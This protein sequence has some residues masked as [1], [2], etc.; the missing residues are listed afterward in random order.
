MKMPLHWFLLALL[1][2]V[3][4]SGASAEQAFWTGNVPPT[5]QARAAQVREWLEGFRQ[6]DRQI[7]TLSPA[8]S[9]WLKTEYD[10]QIA[11]A[12][13]KFTPRASAVTSSTEYY[14]RVAR[15]GIERILADLSTLSTSRQMPRQ[16]E[17][18]AWT[19]VGR[20]HDESP[21]LAGCERSPRSQGLL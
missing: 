18:V 19:R 14:K 2:V 1:L 3:S 15:R 21:I 9:A 12:G 13:G 11:S 10:D 7:P 17:I 5:P 20:G 16:D 8:E 6:M 4:T